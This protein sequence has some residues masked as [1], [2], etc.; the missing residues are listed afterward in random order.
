M[1]TTLAPLIG[2]PSDR[3]AVGAWEWLKGPKVMAVVWTV[4]RIWLGVMWLQAG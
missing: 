2:D 1:T 3:Q 4:M